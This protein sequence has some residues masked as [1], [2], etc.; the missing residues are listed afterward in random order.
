MIGRAAQRA[1]RRLRRKLIVVG[2][3]VVVTALVLIGRH[4]K[5]VRAAPAPHASPSAAAAAAGAPSAA[6]LHG[7]AALQAALGSADLGPS[8]DPLGA[9]VESLAQK[10]LRDRA[11]ASR[12]LRKLTEFSAQ[13]VRCLADDAEAEFPCGQE[14]DEGRAFFAREATPLHD[15]INR[16]LALELALA[17]GAQGADAFA[18]E[19]FLSAEAL[20]AAMATFNPDTQ[21]QSAQLMAVLDGMDSAVPAVLEAAGEGKLT[22]QAEGQLLEYVAPGVSPSYRSTWLDRVGGML[23]SDDPDRFFELLDRLGSLPLTPAE[24]VGAARPL[25]QITRIAALAHNLPAVQRRFEEASRRISGG[26]SSF[27]SWK[28]LC[29]G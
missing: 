9:D 28:E 13:A 11:E 5:S 20:R 12:L 27:V 21:V 10:L 24:L 4:E 25:C 6:P 16:A 14:P 17:Q 22:P 3:A 1:Q 2:M 8:L 15:S 23:S 19:D 29:S 26:A 7:W 18:R